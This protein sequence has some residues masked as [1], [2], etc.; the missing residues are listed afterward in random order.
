[1]KIINTILLA[2]STTSLIFLAACNN[3]TPTSSS[4][5]PTTKLE[6]KT[7]KKITP[8]DTKIS[9]EDHSQSSTSGQVIETEKYHLEFVAEPETNGTHLDFYVRSGDNHDSIDNAKVVSQITLPSGKQNS[10]DFIYDSEGKHYTVF[11]PEASKGKYQI[12][13][14]TDIQGEKV[15]S[16]FAFD[17]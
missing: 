3:F 2:L 5:S 11:L 17:R 4:P 14:Q 8:D 13:M 12:V 16:R 6:V 15:N 7:K 10:L 1:M 9:T